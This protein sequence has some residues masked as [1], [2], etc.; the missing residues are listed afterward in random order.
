[1]TKCIVLVNYVDTKALKFIVA[2]CFSGE[3]FYYAS[4]SKRDEALKA[5][6]DVNGFV[7]ERK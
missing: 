5:A 1:M 3:V 7:V 4:Y 6:Q 2:R